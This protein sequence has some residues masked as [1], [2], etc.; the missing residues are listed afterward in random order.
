MPQFALTHPLWGQHMA[1]L[2]TGWMWFWMALTWVAVI[3][4]IAWIIMRVSGSSRPDPT[5]RARQILSE[6]Y[7]EGKIDTDEY[8]ERLHALR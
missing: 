6:R 5:Q 7:A 2:D 1:G 4:S 8:Q 3:A